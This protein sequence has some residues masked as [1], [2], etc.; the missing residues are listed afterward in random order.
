MRARLTLRP[1][2][3]LPF[4]F[5]RLGSF[6]SRS[7]ALICQGEITYSESLRKKCVQ[8]WSDSIASCAQCMW[9]N[10]RLKCF[11]SIENFRSEDPNAS[12]RSKKNHFDQSLVRPL[13]G[14]FQVAL[15]CISSPSRCTFSISSR[16]SA[17]SHLVLALWVDRISAVSYA[18]ITRGSSS[19]EITVGGW[20]GGRG[21][22]SCS[23]ALV[24]RSRSFSRRDSSS[25]SPF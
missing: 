15:A 1:P 13:L 16:R 9:V 6:F 23:V 4:V 10:S 21:T 11:H 24:S 14:G 3:L 2:P 19:L 8:G 25:A 5:K 18:P 7:C 12:F 20:V 17:S 22:F